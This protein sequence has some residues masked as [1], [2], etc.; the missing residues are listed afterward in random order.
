M[1]ASGRRITSALSGVSC[2]TRAGH[3]PSQAPLSQ[4]CQTTAI[5]VATSLESKGLNDQL[6]NLSD[7][8]SDHQ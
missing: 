5:I 7:N 6:D 2:D 3:C 4:A 8:F 1:T